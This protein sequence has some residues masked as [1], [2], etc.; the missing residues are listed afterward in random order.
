MVERALL[1]GPDK[2]SPEYITLE[3]PENGVSN[4]PVMITSALSGSEIAHAYLS[5]IKSTDMFIK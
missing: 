2:D 1:G 3:N 5:K 4:P